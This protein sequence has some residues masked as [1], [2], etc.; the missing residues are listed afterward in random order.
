MIYEILMNY[1]VTD[2]QNAYTVV[3]IENNEVEIEIKKSVVSDYHFI[4]IKIAGE[5]YVQG[6]ICRAN[7]PIFYSVR[8][9]TL[10]PLVGDFAFLYT[11][12]MLAGR[13]YNPL[14]L[15]TKLKLFYIDDV[16]EE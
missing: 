3:Q 2:T 14:Y 15:G 1:T 6:R 5:Y 8:Q 7:E 4:D 9:D 13:E 10:T 11:T 16:Y 12:E